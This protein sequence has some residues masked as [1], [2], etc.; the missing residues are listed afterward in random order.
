MDLLWEDP[1]PWTACLLVQLSQVLLVSADVRLP[2]R[3]L[4]DFDLF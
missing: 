3:I 1:E 4:Q 2:V